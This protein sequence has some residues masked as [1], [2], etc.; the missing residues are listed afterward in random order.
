HSTN[1][2]VS[3]KTTYSDKS[4]FILMNEKADTLSDESLF[5]AFVRL[6]APDGIPE[7]WIVPSTVVAPVIKE[8]YKIWLETPA[9]NGSAHNETSMRG[10]YL[11]KY[12]GFP[13]DWEEQLESFKSNIKMLEEFVFHI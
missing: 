12:L 7:F 6:N 4:K 8:S 11:Q 13:K 2:V 10:F 9:R 3:V 1:L 5:Y